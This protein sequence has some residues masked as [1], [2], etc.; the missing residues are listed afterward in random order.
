VGVQ[1]GR[2][3]IIGGRWRGRRLPVPA[4]PALRPTPDRVRETLFNWLAPIIDGARCLDC[5]AG[6]GALAF[7]ALSRGAGHCVLV[8]SDPGVARHLRAQA[9]RLGA[10]DAEIHCA[11]V[12]AWLRGN[13]REFDIVFVDAP[14]DS[15]L[16][17]EACL[18]VVNGRNL[19]PAGLLYVE[20]TPGWQPPEGLFDVRKQGRAG[21]VQYMLLAAHAGEQE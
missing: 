16:A 15:G 14:F 11:D 21:Q 8:E 2:V 7:E 18:L 1:P 4:A 20:S 13:A 9:Q 17:S 10:D 6:T 19:A 12:R 5:F 3:R